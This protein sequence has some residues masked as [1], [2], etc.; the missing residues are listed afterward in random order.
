MDRAFHGPDCPLYHSHACCQVANADFFLKMIPLFDAGDDVGMVLS[1]QAF[2]N[3][4]VRCD[5]FNHSNVQF[6]EYAQTGYDALPF[7]SC[8]G[9]PAAID[10]ASKQGSKQ[11]SSH[12]LTQSIMP[13]QH[14]GWL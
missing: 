13:S 11:A 3:I 9:G 5:V 1:P 2:H 10:Q 6:W 7:I 12:L 14:Y 4:D 8:T